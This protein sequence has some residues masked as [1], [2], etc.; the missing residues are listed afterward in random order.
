[1]ATSDELKVKLQE[2][3]LRIVGAA[4]ARDAIQLRKLQRRQEI[5]QK[6]L[7][8]VESKEE[9][10]RATTDEKIKERTLLLMR[11]YWKD[12]IYEIGK[13]LNIDYFNRYEHY[14]RIDHY[15]GALEISKV[16]ADQELLGLIEDNLP[17]YKVPLGGFRGTYYSATEDGEVT[18][19]D[20]RDG[21]RANVRTALGRWGEKAYGVMQ[22]LINRRGR[23][24]FFDLVDEI[25]KVLGYEY[26]P[27]WLLP[28]MV[29]MKLVFKTGSR[30]Y[31][32]WTMPPEMVPVVRQELEAYTRPRKRPR[33]QSTVSSEV[34][35]VEGT[36]EAI[37]SEIVRRRRDINL[38]F[39]G[40]FGTQLF[41]QNEMA[42]ADIRKPC[43]N[44]EDFNNRILNL[45][46]L[47]NVIWTEEITQLVKGKQPEPGS[48]NI[49][50]AFLE[51]E[52]PNYDK[53][54]IA[55]LRMMNRLRSKKH[56]IHADTPELM[57][58]LQY[59]GFGAF[60]PDWQ[61]LWEAVLSKYLETL[62]S[63][64]KVMQ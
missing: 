20:S 23:A 2:I 42:T 4:A 1:M 24:T 52:F 58:A 60:P 41:R 10:D 17:Q 33:T 15:R 49:L 18:L 12:K 7:G 57:E 61:E 26:V 56:P 11:F 13:G 59:F 19:S 21:V 5:L 35:V 50:E 9:Q 55:N 16:V 64:A 30:K 14:W 25:E 37:A 63:L 34:I 46:N 45:T 39:M 27:S 36:M 29:P 8:E 54:I 22:A 31:P 43:S 48:I 6:Q 53:Q 28:R 32:D 40:R 47:I 51:Q 62:Q 38:A 44:E 3:E